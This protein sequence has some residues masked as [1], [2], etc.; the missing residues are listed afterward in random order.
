MGE[1]YFK[2]LKPIIMNQSPKEKAKELFDQYYMLI[3]NTG[4]ELSNEIIISILAKQS[5]LIAVK[6]IL[7][8]DLNNEVYYYWEEVEEE[9]N[10]L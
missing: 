5:C 1:L 10:N 2:F 8:N 9:I 7:D 3:L 6:Q 4:G